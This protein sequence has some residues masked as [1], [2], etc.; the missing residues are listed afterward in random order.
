LQSREDSSKLAFLLFK[1]AC[2]HCKNRL[3]CKTCLPTLQKSPPYSAK[4]TSLLC[5][6]RL[7]TLQKSPPYSSK[8]AYLLCKNRLLCKNSLLTLQESP[9]YSATLQIKPLYSA[10]TASLLCKNCLPTMQKLPTMQNSLPTRHNQIADVFNLVHIMTAFLLRYLTISMST[11][12]SDS[13][14][15]KW[16][17]TRFNSPHINGYIHI[18]I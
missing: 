3:L 2:L 11:M 12:Q 14:P 1:K 4:I 18:V 13:I 5:K 15:I 9:P 17:I 7:H 6:N 10:K 8:L 16:C